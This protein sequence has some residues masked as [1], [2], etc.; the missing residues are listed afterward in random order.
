MDVEIASRTRISNIINPNEIMTTHADTC[1]GES[2][3]VIDAVRIDKSLSAEQKD[4]IK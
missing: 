4:E 3:D 1:L 2:Y